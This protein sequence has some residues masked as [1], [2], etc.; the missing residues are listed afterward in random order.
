RPQPGRRRRARTPPGKGGSRLPSGPCQCR[1][2]HD[3]LVSRF[4]PN[5]FVQ[6]LL[7]KAQ[8]LRISF[9]RSPVP[10][11]SL[12][13]PGRRATLVWEPDLTSQ[14]LTYLVVILAHEMGHAV[15]FDQNPERR[16]EVHGMHWLDVPDEV[17]IAAFVQGFLLLK[18]LRIP[19]SLDDYQKMIAEPIGAAV[20]RE[21]QENHLCCLLSSSRPAAAGGKAAC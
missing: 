13:H 9:Q 20:R 19:I 14:S 7:A 12:Y 4:P 5:P 10:E 8:E 6:R 2:L 11:Q 16:R 15:D 17:E 18:E 1:E 3:T 21:I